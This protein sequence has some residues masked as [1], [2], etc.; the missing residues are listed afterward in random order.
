VDLN[1]L[2]EHFAGRCRDVVRVPWDG[3]LEEGAEVDLERLA[4]AT[5]DAYLQLAASVG[6]AFAW[7]R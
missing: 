5:R 7:Q 6:E 3:H 1:R 2:E 4:P